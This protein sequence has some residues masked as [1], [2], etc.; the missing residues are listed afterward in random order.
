MRDESRR[1]G[2]P[3]QQSAEQLDGGGVG[4][5]EVVQHED[6]RPG[7]R[8]LLEQCANRAVA[9]IA[10]VLKGHGAATCDPGQ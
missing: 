7:V 4:P 6:Q 9:A 2:G 3:A 1:C 5:V 10:L 8:K